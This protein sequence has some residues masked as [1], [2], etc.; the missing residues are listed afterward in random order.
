[1]AKTANEQVLDVLAQAKQPVGLASLGK[2]LG[3]RGVKYATVS[4][5]TQ[6][7]VKR[8]Q[9]V[10]VRRGVY[11]L[12]EFAEATATASKAAAAP[13]APSLGVS[14]GQR[15]T[16][17]ARQEAEALQE[18]LDALG[19]G[20]ST[21]DRLVESTGW[22]RADLLA[23]LREASWAGKVH[24][25][26]RGSE[27]LYLLAGEQLAPHDAT[28]AQ[29]GASSIPAAVT[30]APADISR[31]DVGTVE[32]AVLRAIPAGGLPERLTAITQDIEDALGDACDAQLPHDLIKALVV[33]NGA[34]HRA[35]RLLGA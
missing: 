5:A 33:A 26:A 28:E 2:Q 12:P 17:G 27:Q 1:V 21:F 34:A 35:A 22:T 8:E 16:T 24:C 23:Q 4:K 9:I 10:L 29:E 25:V 18:L 15:D 32:V 7:L 31:G 6:E 11:A 30:R 20:P 13:L 3:A 14:L 19:D